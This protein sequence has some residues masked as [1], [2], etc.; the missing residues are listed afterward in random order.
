MN[1]YVK[2]VIVVLLVIGVAQF[3]PQAVNILLLLILAGM[4]LMQSGQF[5]AL[6]AQL[7]L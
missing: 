5:A 4:V 2:L 7:K 3:A 1:Y 6:V